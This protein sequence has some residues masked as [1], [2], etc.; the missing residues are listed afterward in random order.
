MSGGQCHAG[1][2]GRWHSHLLQ[3]SKGAP[4][5][6]GKTSLFS[7]VSLKLAAR[8]KKKKH[9]LRLT[10]PCVVGINCIVVCLK[11][12]LQQCPSVNVLD[13]NLKTG[14]LTCMI[15]LT[16][17]HQSPIVDVNIESCKG[18]RSVCE[19]RGHTMKGGTRQSRSGPETWN[20][21]KEGFERSGGH[22]EVLARQ[23]RYCGGT[24]SYHSV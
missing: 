21:N 18:S 13:W 20:D 10:I 9:W 4:R 8:R 6:I 15:S 12:F 14:G 23:P 2:V 24:R 1:L 7:N 5:M 3:S 19:S 11:L 22:G 17:G 16:S